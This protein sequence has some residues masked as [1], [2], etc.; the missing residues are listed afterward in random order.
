MSPENNQSKCGFQEQLK[1]RGIQ[2]HSRVGRKARG[3]RRSLSSRE[4]RA[5]FHGKPWFYVIQLKTLQFLSVSVK[6][7][8]FGLEFCSA[9]SERKPGEKRGKVESNL[10]KDRSG[11]T[12]VLGRKN[13]FLSGNRSIRAEPL[14][15]A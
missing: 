6:N 10:V 8:L 9:G 11:K 7:L 5:G 3:K 12:G 1:T 15:K 4:V 13:R 2:F 14:E